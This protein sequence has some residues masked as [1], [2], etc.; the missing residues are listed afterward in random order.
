MLSGYVEG[1]LED[2][3][4]NRNLFYVLFFICMNSFAEEN[5]RITFY[6]LERS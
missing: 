4:D 5:G 2:R 6:Y 3:R 1:V